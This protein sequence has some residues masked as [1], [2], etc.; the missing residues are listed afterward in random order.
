MTK[1]ALHIKILLYVLLSV[2]LLYTG[3]QLVR[4]YAGAHEASE[5]E[6][7]RSE[8]GTASVGS[9]SVGI[10]SRFI[11]FAVFAAALGFLIARDFSSHVG[12]KFGELVFNEDLKGVYT[13]EYERAE[14]EAT[15]GNFLEAVRLMRI[16]Y[17]AH[18]NEVY[19]LIRIA[20]IYEQNLHN[21][22]A[23][24]LEYEE[25]LKLPLPPERW[26]WAAIH[27]VNLYSGRLGRRD[28][29][30]ALLQ[31]IV[32]E[33]GHTAAA[34]KARARLGIPEP[35]P[36]PAPVRHDAAAEDEAPAGEDETVETDPEPELPSNLPSGFRVRKSGPAGAARPASDMM[37][38]VRDDSA[39][40]APPAN[41]PPGFRPKG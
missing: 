32:S 17:A 31:R 33:C 24:A 13:P 23:A 20:E 30:V 29:A 11:S 36:P 26:G 3:M 2:G 21:H 40:G 37:D 7:Q 14:T 6:R 18:P 34:R 41:L 10:V 12:H 27:L 38:Y 22:V 5:A 25:I 16:H 4:H 28:D 39:E 19:V 9:G 35:E 1:Y 8:G 15:A